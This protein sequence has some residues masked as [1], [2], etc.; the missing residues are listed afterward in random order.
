M[1]PYP[2]GQRTVSLLGIDVNAQRGLQPTRHWVHRERKLRK[3]ID[4]DE[5]QRHGVVVQQVEFETEK[6]KPRRKS[7][8]RSKG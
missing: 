5:R 3:G 4:G 2:R 8:D 6:F 7:L 1:Q